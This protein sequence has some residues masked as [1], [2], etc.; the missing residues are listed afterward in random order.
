MK[1]DGKSY[2]KVKV[3]LVNGNGEVV[4]EADKVELKFDTTAGNFANQRVT[5]QNGVAEN[6]LTSESLIAP[7]TALITVTIINAKDTNLINVTNT[8]NIVLDPSPTTEVDSTVGATLTD[9]K[10]QTA[11]KVALFFNKKVNVKDYTSNNKA[12][13]YKVYDL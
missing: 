1:A 4:K 11:D 5:V 7:K 2:T 8:M 13:N 12:N 3:S 6:I 9:I 10:V